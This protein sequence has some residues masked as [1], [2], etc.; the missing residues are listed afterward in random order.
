MLWAVE[1]M[2]KAMGFLE[3]DGDEEPGVMSP[4][5]CSGHCTEIIGWAKCRG[6]AI[7]VSGPV[8]AGVVG[9]SY[10]GSEGLLRGEWGS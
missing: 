7:A 5:A 9:A 10:V 6:R 1:A 3:R 8:E 2:A 4:S